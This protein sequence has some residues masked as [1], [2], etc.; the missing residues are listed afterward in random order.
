MNDLN[1][2]ILGMTLLAAYGD[3]LGAPHELA[4]LKGEAEDTSKNLRLRP[5]SACFPREKDKITEWWV[6]PDHML[7]PREQRGMVTDDTAFRVMILEPWLLEDRPGR[8]AIFEDSLERWMR[9]HVENPPR[10]WPARVRERFRKMVRGWIVMFEDARRFRE[11][12]ADFERSKSNPFWRPEVATIFGPFL[13]GE[14]GA[15]FASRPRREVF[16][17]FVSMTSLDYGIGRLFTA[18]IGVLVSEAMG[19]ASTESLDAWYARLTDEVCELAESS[20][21]EGRGVSKS[22]IADFRESWM[23][24]RGVG[25][26]MRKFD[27]NAF[28]KKLVAEIY[29]PRLRVNPHGLGAFGSRVAFEQIS[30]CVAYSGDDFRKA[31]RLLTSGPGDADTLPSFLGLVFGARLGATAIRKSHASLA[32]DL[33]LVETVLSKADYFGIDLKERVKKLAQWIESRAKG[34]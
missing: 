21:L 2:K 24:S 33:G 9:R 6:W 26:S 32:D 30:A 28:L 1:D 17:A 11:H 13:F 14:L 29:Q 19:P 7:V 10:E 16:D 8:E 34:R 3:A 31:L 23:R 22:D 15:L 5:F 25:R 4:G 18:Q 20:N 27:E 12:P